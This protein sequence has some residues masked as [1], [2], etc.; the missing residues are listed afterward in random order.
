MSK[1]DEDK[2]IEDIEMLKLQNFSSK[3]KNILRKIQQNK[4]KGYE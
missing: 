1:I 2:I 4:F 3:K